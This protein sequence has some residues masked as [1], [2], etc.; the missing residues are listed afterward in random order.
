MSTTAN[1]RAAQQAGDG[2]RPSVEL[3]ALVE[4]LLAQRVDDDRARIQLTSSGPIH[5]AGDRTQLRFA[6]GN[7]I[8]LMLACSPAASRLSLRISAHGRYA[9]IGISAPAVGHRDFQLALSGARNAIEQHG[10]SVAVVQLAD[11]IRLAVALP[12]L[13]SERKAAGSVLIVDD[14]AEQVRALS[15]VLRHEGY[16][17]EFALT[18]REALARLDTNV[19][20]IVI[21]DMQIPDMTGADVI[22]FARE[23]K[24]HVSA[25]LLTGYPPEHPLIADALAST[26]SAYLAKPV[27]V[28]ELFALLVSASRTT[29]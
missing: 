10:G 19:P 3:V 23:R 20:D 2:D 18:G 28:D 15:E 12:V 1:D 14:D 11:A 16:T 24:P 7:I 17:I 6:I 5:V 13:R 29:T 27:N 25:L 26:Q 9:Q 8:H 21:V 22:R 4:S